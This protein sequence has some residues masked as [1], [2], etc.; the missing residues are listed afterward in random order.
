MPINYYYELTGIITDSEIILHLI[1]KYFPELEKIIN[2]EYMTIKNFI[3]KWIITIFTNDFQKELGYIIWDFLLLQG[4]IVIF[5]SVL[6]LFSILKKK[7][8]ACKEKDE[9]IYS[10]F[11][12]TLNIESKNKKLLFGLA[13]KNYEDLT[14]K[15]INKIRNKINPIVFDNIIKINKNSYNIKIKNKNLTTNKCDEKWPICLGNDKLRSNPINHLNFIVFKTPSNTKYYKNYFFDEINNENNN[16]FNDYENK[17]DNTHMND[18]ND[19]YNIITERENHHCC[20][21]INTEI[22]IKENK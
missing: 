2:D 14:E 11:E 5:K 8:I 6:S 10:I 12:E 21:L 3:N 1:K 13:I 7:I 18:I 4:N 20:S 16:I 22:D 19:L 9:Y 15:Y 17:K